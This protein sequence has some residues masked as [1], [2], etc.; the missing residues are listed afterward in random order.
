MADLNLFETVGAQWVQMI[1]DRIH[2]LEVQVQ[3]LQVENT[4]LEE[5]VKSCVEH[6]Q[7]CVLGPEV[8]EL[9]AC[10]VWDVSKDWHTALIDATSDAK[11][12]LRPLTDDEWNTVVITGKGAALVHC[13]V[14]W[15][16]GVLE[17]REVLT[18]CT[19]KDLICELSDFYSPIVR[20][21][22][23]TQPS[24]IDDSTTTFPHDGGRLLRLAFGFLGEGWPRCCRRTGRTRSR[25]ASLL[26]A[27]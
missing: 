25:S 5:H 1:M 7:A 27:G 9:L 8:E 17:D 3:S 6:V 26:C 11:P 23:G 21:I 2:E 16:E 20:D 15:C 10:V 24:H 22:G 13:P 14:F 4:R 12:L 18:P 19:L